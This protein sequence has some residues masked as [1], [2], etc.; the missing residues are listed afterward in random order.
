M[1]QVVADVIEACPAQGP[2]ALENTQRQHWRSWAAAVKLALSR[3]LPESDAEWDLVRTCL[4]WHP[5]ARVTM[6]SAKQPAWF[7]ERV[8]IPE[9]VLTSQAGTCADALSLSTACADASTLRANTSKK[10]TWRALPGG[11][12]AR[13]STAPRASA[14]ALSLSSARPAATCAIVLSRG[15]VAPGSRATSAVITEG[16]PMRL[17]SACSWLWLQFQSRPS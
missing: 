10:R 3:L 1:V 12:A 4:R 15:A 8:A 2:G 17:R 9:A 5:S 16:L 6:A 7:P 13:T 14:T 11:T